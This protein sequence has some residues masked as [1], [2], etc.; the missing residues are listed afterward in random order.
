MIYFLNIFLISISQKIVMK[1]D[2]YE[3]VMKRDDYVVVMKRDDR[4][5]FSRPIVIKRD[6]SRKSHKG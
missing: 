1:R 3:I 2:D 4:H 5:P 6:D